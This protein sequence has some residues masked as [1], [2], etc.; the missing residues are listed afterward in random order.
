MS[1]IRKDLRLRDI[2]TTDDFKGTRWPH[3]YLSPTGSGR[4]FSEIQAPK[5]R[6]GSLF[7]L[8][9]HFTGRWSP[10]VLSMYRNKVPLKLLC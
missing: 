10:F 7:I 6:L 2:Y 3:I 4:G 5:K 8:K 1:Q 9:N